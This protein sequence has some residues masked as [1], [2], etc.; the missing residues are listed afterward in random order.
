MLNERADLAALYPAHLAFLRNRFDKAL[1]AT[2]FDRVVIGAGAQHMMF[3][4][5]MPYAFRAYAMFKWWVPVTDNPNC[6][7]IHAKG[8]ARPTVL[9]WQPRDYWHLPAAAPTAYWAERCEVIAIADP[10]EL[11]QHLPSDLSRT[12]F[13]GEAEPAADALGFGARNPDALVTH[14]EHWRGYKTEHELRCFE[15]ATERGVRAHRAAEA[16]FRA[17]A[18]EF[19]IHV[20]YQRA[21]GQTERDLPYG[22]I[23]AL[24]EMA[25]VLHY[26]H[27]RSQRPAATRSFL[28]DA[29]AQHAGYACDITR[30]YSAADD[31]FAALIEGMDAAQRRLCAAVKPGLPYPELQKQ[32]HLEVGALLKEHGLVDLSPEAAFA[33]R[34]THAF[35]PHGVGH[36]LGLNVHD[37]GGF[38]RSERGGT[39]DKPQG[40]PNLRLTRPIEE[41]MVF[42]VEPG[43]YFIPLLLDELKAKP[44]AKSVDWTRVAAFLPFGGI[45]IEDDVVVTKTGHRNLTREEFGRQAV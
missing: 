20:E 31:D 10:A 4:D 32:T 26:Q 18:S 44:Q 37:A 33:E 19:E 34:V 25:A 42:T 7:V 3:R 39:L 2:G 45:R 27:Q 30:T 16:A 8:A 11:A 12:A 14:L 17:G 36:L 24:N 13:L 9:F 41:H 1:D 29:G 43:L 35:F 21:A 28:I 23:I 6:Y 15:L 5:D 40:E 22:N 38:S